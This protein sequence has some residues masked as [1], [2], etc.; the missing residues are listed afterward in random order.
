MTR[1]CIA[2]TH[3]DERMTTINLTRPLNT[4]RPRGVPSAPS[5]W[6]NAVPSMA[7]SPQDVKYVKI[8]AKPEKFKVAVSTSAQELP[9]FIAIAIANPSTMPSYRRATGKAQHN[10]YRTKDTAAPGCHKR[11]PGAGTLEL[12][13][14]SDPF[15]REQM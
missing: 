9:K 5:Q 8:R 2:L 6:I 14:D 13:H 10:E 1:D 15:A 12:N 11:E 7:H 4:V 3:C